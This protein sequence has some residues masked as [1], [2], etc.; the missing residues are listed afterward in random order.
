MLL[1]YFF[2]FLFILICTLLFIFFYTLIPQ[3]SGGETEFFSPDDTDILTSSSA[4]TARNRDKKRAMVFCSPDKKFASRRFM[5]SGHKDCNLFK[6]LYGAEYDCSWGCIGFGSCVS[7]CPQDAII[8]KN[9]TAVITESCDGCGVCIP[10]CPNNLIKLVPETP[11]FVVQCST[12]DGTNTSCSNACTACGECIDPYIT[13][14]FTIIDNLSVSDYKQNHDKSG[15]A[16]KCPQKCIKKIELPKKNDFKFW[17][18]CYT[19]VH[20]S[21]DSG[22]SELWE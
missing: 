1:L 13:S 18:L 14:G 15:F 4:H 17:K 2:V 22:E 20:K 10:Y 7:H 8:I 21:K 16:V 6:T 3:V 12:H 19:I 11:D 9:N 5:Y